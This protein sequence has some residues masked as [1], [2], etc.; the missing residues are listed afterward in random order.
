MSQSAVV[1]F[2]L[3]S[4]QFRSGLV[5]GPAEAGRLRQGTS[6]ITGRNVFIRHDIRYKAEAVCTRLL[7]SKYSTLNCCCEKDDSINYLCRGK[8]SLKNNLDL[9]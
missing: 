9:K 7:S 5:L 8:F 3:H 2:L 4:N 1:D 6:S